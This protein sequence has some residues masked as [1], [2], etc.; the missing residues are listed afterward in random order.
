MTNLPE[1]GAFLDTRRIVSALG[2][3]SGLRV[4][5]LGCGAGFFTIDLARAVG[6]D[7]IISAA[8]IMEEPLQSV[9]ARASAAGLEN[10]RTIRADLEVLGGTKI[11]DGS[12]D[13][14]LVANVLFQSQKKE[15]ILAEA[16]RIL[17][18][19]GRLLVVDWKKGAGGFGPP[20][21]LRTDEATMQALVGSVGVRFQQALD[22]GA[23]YYALLFIK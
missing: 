13:L 15:A 2:G 3:L 23:F 8:D 7:G 6:K 20:E 5:D 16:V 21:S 14:V 19:G 4:A 12:Q 18:S 11:A 10:V 1:S 9:Q 22:A 17:R